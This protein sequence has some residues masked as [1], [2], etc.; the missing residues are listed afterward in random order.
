MWED[1]SVSTHSLTYQPVLTR[2]QALQALGLNLDNISNTE[3]FWG[4]EKVKPKIKNFL[5]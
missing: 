1:F 4:A 5:M 3:N 2:L